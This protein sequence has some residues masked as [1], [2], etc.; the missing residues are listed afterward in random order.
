[1]AAEVNPLNAC[2]EF[3][4][5]R[6]GDSLP[7]LAVVVQGLDLHGAVANCCLNQARA[8]SRDYRITIYS[9]TGSHKLRHLGPR[10]ILRRLRI[11][12]LTLL[13]RL[14]HVPRE[15]AFIL[16]AGFSL[17]TSP[18]RHRPA[19]VIFHSHPATALLAPL[20]RRRLRCVTML[21]MHGDIH[22]RPPGTY[23]SRLTAWYQ[24]TTR[25]AYRSVDAIIALSPYMRQ[26]ALAGGADAE[27][28]FLVPNGVDPA[29]IGLPPQPQVSPTPVVEHA[30]NLRLLFIGRIEHNKGPDLLIA[31]CAPLRRRF[32]GLS[33]TC[34]G[35]PNPSFM[36]GLQQQIAE[37]G[38]QSRVTFLPPQPR[39]QLGTHYLDASLVVVP[40]RSETQSTVLMEAMAA[41][42][43]VVASDTGGNAMMVD[44]GST[45]L[46]FAPDDPASLQ[47]A[48]EQLLADPSLLDSMGQ[49]A[50]QRHAALYS[51]ER[52]AASLQEAVAAIRRL[53]PRHPAPRPQRTP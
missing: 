19:A 17:V 26:Y 37:A 40:S 13:R 35:A 30:T 21:V 24:A 12:K 27:R 1:M 2:Q 6:P 33:I 22:D 36:A 29:E 34:I 48:L 9:D 47:E 15:F 44:H 53:G 28:V 7:A 8:L 25:R 10:L 43:A 50:L 4:N 41:G 49:A 18:S 51:A 46:L 11:P 31:A 32:P 39:H 23:D 3:L 38:L 14:A 20:L 16:A 52:S 45:G 42:R 5:L